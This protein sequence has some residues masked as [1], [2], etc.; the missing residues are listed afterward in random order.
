MVIPTNTKTLV[1]LTAF[2]LAATTV[3]FVPT[4]AAHT[5]YSLNPLDCGS[6]VSG[7]HEHTYCRSW[8]TELIAS[9]FLA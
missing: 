2:A 4:T 5:C 6:C 7:T 9:G 3:A 8:T 1:L